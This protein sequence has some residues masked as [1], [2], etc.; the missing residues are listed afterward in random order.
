MAVTAGEKTIYNAVL[1]WRKKRSR[2]D[3]ILELEG[4]PALLGLPFMRNAQASE[5]QMVH[6]ELGLIAAMDELTGPA[7]AR[8]ILRETL[9]GEGSVSARVRIARERVLQ[10]MGLP[11]DEASWGEEERFRGERV[12]EGLIQTR[13]YEAVRRLANVIRTREFAHRFAA[14]TGIAPIPGF[15]SMAELSGHEE[16]AILGAVVGARLPAYEASIDLAMCDHRDPALFV[17]RN[18]TN[19]VATSE[20]YVLALVEEAELVDLLVATCPRVKDVWSTGGIPLAR[21]EKQL[22]E[23]MR[24]VSRPIDEYGTRPPVTHTLIPVAPEDKLAYLNGLPEDVLEMVSLF[25]AEIKAGATGRVKIH[26][27]AALTLP[28]NRNCCRWFAERAMEVHKITCDYS[29]FSYGNGNFECRLFPFLGTVSTMAEHD[30]ERRRFELQVDNW[31]V[32][33]QGIM[34]V[35]GASE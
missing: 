9:L 32:K 34:I 19:L 10:E 27:E 13:D 15:N 1:E 5:D 8:V 6:F 23:T 11:E 33:G 12:T 28:K 21:A 2:A 7:F 35:W 16:T 18:R 26:T 31:V 30:K 3:R 25:A 29:Q 24:V 22:K 14:R 4:S 17:W 20:D